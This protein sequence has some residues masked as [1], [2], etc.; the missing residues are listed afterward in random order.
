MNIYGLMEKYENLMKD[1]EK[2]QDKEILYLQKSIHVVGETISR[3][4]NIEDLQ[5]DTLF[6]KESFQKIVS[7]NTEFDFNIDTIEEAHKNI[8][9]SEI[10]DDKLYVKDTV[11][12]EVGQQTTFKQLNNKVNQV[13]KENVEKKSEY[14][15]EIDKYINS[16]FDK[17]DDSETDKKLKEYF[18]AVSQF[19][20]YSRANIM[21]LQSQASETGISISHVSSYK[22]WSELGA[23]VKKGSK[24]L[25]VFAP[26]TL[27]KIKKDNEGKPIKKGKYWDYEK[28]ENGNKIKDGITFVKVPVFDVSQTNAME[29]GLIKNLDYRNIEVDI[30]DEL[31][32]DFTNE[33]SEKF[34]IDITF[35]DLNNAKLGGY[36]RPSDHSIT[37]NNGSNRTNTE[38]LSTLFHELGHAQLHNEDDYEAIHLDR[39]EKEGEAESVSYILSMKC[40]IENNSELYIKSWG[41]DTDTL[42][43]R[44]ERITSAS[45][46]VMKQIN[47]EEILQRDRERLESVNV[48]DEL[49]TFIKELENSNK[50]TI[51]IKEDN[52][53]EEEKSS[54]KKRKHK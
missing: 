3:E 34:N 29:L 12:Y 54:S 50:E 41:N 48:N 1:F 19:N 18:Q 40:G 49:D 45:L 35:T 9:N 47:F 14:T 2:Q 30:S 42:K 38:Q 33:I 39:G 43:D 4:F 52:K 32:E 17:I 16:L 25:K 22:K 8:N 28:D 31:V 24:S 11:V 7:T 51:E 44:L 6:D 10:R 46:D 27:F 26:K 5:Q 21:Y 53:N 36:Y 15:Q 23:Q 37:I 20:K 13:I